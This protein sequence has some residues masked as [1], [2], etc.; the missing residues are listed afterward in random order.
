M[1][2]CNK[3]RAKVE[4]GGREVNIELVTSENQ[5]SHVLFITTTKIGVS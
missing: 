3:E 2:D 1:E 5:I 4:E